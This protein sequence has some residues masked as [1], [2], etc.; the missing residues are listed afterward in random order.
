M[1]LSTAVLQPLPYV[2]NF[3][4]PTRVLC[5]LLGIGKVINCVLYCLREHATNNAG[6]C[7]VPFMIVYYMNWHEFSCPLLQIGR[8][9][10]HI[11]GLSKV[12]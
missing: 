7:I 6:Q 10:L 12:G 9:N 1:L 5:L 2:Y 8:Y 11:M 4:I 3:F